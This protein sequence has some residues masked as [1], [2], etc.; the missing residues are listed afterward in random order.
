M[1]KCKKAAD[2]GLYFLRMA[3]SCPSTCTGPLPAIDWRVFH[4]VFSSPSLLED[5]TTEN[6]QSYAI[7]PESMT[8]TVPIRSQLATSVCLFQITAI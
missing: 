6:H 2:F 1:R 7:I 5:N 4:P 3:G 8:S